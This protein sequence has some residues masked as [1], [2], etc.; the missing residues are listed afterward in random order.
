MSPTIRISD[1][2]YRA[3]QNLARP[4]EDTP[5]SVIRRLL[6][7]AEAGR[8]PER[9]AREPA[10]RARPQPVEGEKT[11]QAAFRAPLI[12]ALQEAGGRGRTSEVIDRVGEILGDEL[13]NG[14]FEK[15]SGGDIR[16][17]N[18]TAWVR[19]HLV[20]EGVMRDNSPT[21]IWELNPDYLQTD[22]SEV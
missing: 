12:Q 5:D 16:W 22:P 4:F 20:K 11:S 1:E 13:K 17:R 7:Q 6:E 9:V 19:F 21:G 14:D 2:T 18:T 3:L 15:V 10:S 8:P